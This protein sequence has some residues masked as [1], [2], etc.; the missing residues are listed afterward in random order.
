M[1]YM[2]SGE[3]GVE[4]INSVNSHRVL[5]PMVGGMLMAVQSSPGWMSPI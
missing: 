3:F 2:K 1:L 5:V 4:G